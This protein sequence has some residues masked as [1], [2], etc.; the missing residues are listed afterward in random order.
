VEVKATLHDS[1]HIT[2]TLNLL[3]ELERKRPGEF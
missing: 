2:E 3:K 1:R